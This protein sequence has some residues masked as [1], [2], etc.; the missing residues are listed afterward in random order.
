MRK[1][2]IIVTSPVIVWF[3][4][5]FRLMDNAALSAAVATGAP[6][7]CIYILDDATEQVAARWWLG[8]AL[9]L[10]DAALRRRNGALHVFRGSANRVL[11]AVVAATR[12]RA[13][14]WNRRYDP[15]GKETDTRLKTML[16]AAGTPVHSFAGA[17]LHEPWTIQTRTGQPYR[18]FGAYWRAACQAGHERPLLPA[19]ERLTFATPAQAGLPPMVDPDM[20]SQEM[21]ATGWTDG[22]DEAWRPDEVSAHTVLETFVDGPL[23]DYAHDRDM[24]AQPATSR[25]SPFLRWGHITPAQIREA[26]VARSQSGGATKFMMELGW[27]DFAWS[28]LFGCPDLVSRNLRPEFD[29]M[30]WRHDPSGLRAWQRGLT[31]YPLVDAGMRQLWQ[32]GWMHNR[33]RMV[34]ASFLVK[35]LLIDWREG[36]RWFAHTLVDY[37]PA[38]NGM[39]WQWVAGTGIDAAPFFRIMNPLIQSRKFDPSGAYIRSWVPELSGLPDKH[40]HTPWLAG[41]AEGYPPPIV[42]HE[43]ARDRALSAWRMLRGATP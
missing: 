43:V 33:V 1:E 30:A 35:H 17:L 25:L 39:N 15:G 13:V 36:E 14:F 31:G 37:D 6:V 20:I 3:R 11:P 27:R 32:T 7:L 24:P 18:V 9:E 4:H 34:A 8:R 38:S 16:K 28:V 23:E 5:D 40:I 19:P 26:V 10:F 12:A 42:S 2:P 21:H 22:L 29:M 41:G